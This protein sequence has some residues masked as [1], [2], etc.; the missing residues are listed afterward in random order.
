MSSKSARFLQDLINRRSIRKLSK[1]PP[2]LPDE[3]LIN[4]VR[5]T[6]KHSPSAFNSQSSRAIILLGSEHDIFWSEDVPTAVKSAN[7]DQAWLERIMPKLPMFGVATGTVLFFESEAVVKANQE[8]SPAFASLFPYWSHQASGIAQSNTWTALSAEGY[9][10]NL[11][12]L[13]EVGPSFIKK[14]GLPEDYKLIAQLVFG[15]PNEM[16]GEKSFLP[17][18]QKVKVFGASTAQL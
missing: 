13:N 14:H 6:V 12:H 15:V 5:Q 16:P 3:H 17:D 4:L 7:N 8:R 10:C 2:I 1:G 9:G 11:Q 18:E